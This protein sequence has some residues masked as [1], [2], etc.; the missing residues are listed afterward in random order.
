MKTRNINGF[1]LID[2]CSLK[3]KNAILFNFYFR[4][5]SLFQNFRLFLAILTNIWPFF[6]GRHP[7][8]SSP[9]HLSHPSQQAGN[10][11]NLG[12]FSH[13]YDGQRQQSHF[14]RT[15]GE[16]LFFYKS[17]SWILLFYQWFNLYVY[18]DSVYFYPGQYSQTICQSQIGWYHFGAG[19]FSWQ[20]PVHSWKAGPGDVM[21]GENIISF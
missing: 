16:S 6:T 7:E 13:F 5:L 3:K 21:T 10:N 14:P 15:S 1:S 4:F 19:A 11:R 18:Q 20:D 8:L 12:L 9:S 2:L 17:F